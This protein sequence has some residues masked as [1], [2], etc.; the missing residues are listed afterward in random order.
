VKANEIELNK[1]TVDIKLKQTIFRSGGTSYVTKGGGQFELLRT[2]KTKKNAKVHVNFYFLGEKCIDWAEV[3]ESGLPHDHAGIGQRGCVQ[4][5][6]APVL[7]SAL[8]KFKWSEKVS[9]G[10]A[11]KLT[12]DIVQNN[13]RTAELDIVLNYGGEKFTPKRNNFMGSYTF[14]LSN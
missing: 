6:L 5:E 4:Y 12:V 8:V 13:E 9:F 3:G 2:H 1:N 7:F 14:D 10:V 11:E